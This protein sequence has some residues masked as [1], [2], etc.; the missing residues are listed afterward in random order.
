MPLWLSVPI[1]AVLWL[2]SWISGLDFA[3]GDRTQAYLTWGVTALASLLLLVS[4]VR[5]A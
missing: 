5:R 4:L 1:V 3:T 2:S